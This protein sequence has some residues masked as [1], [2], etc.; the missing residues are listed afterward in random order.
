MQG[1]NDLNAA[2]VAIS[3]R[4]RFGD[5]G[6]KSAAMFCPQRLLTDKIVVFSSAMAIASDCD[7]FRDFSRK[8]VPA[9]VWLVTGDFFR[10]KMAAI[11]DCDFGAL[12]S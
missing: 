7:F 1:D 2:H 5:A 8:N 4:L 6:Q 11:C 3:L 12:M 9:A 10:Q